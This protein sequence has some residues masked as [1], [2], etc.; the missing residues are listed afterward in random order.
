MERTFCS[1][2]PE[3]AAPRSQAEP[4]ALSSPLAHG[5]LQVTRPASFLLHGTAAEGARGLPPRPRSGRPGHRV[6]PGFPAEGQVGS[7]RCHLVVARRAAPRRPRGLGKPSLPPPGGEPSPNPAL[8][9][10]LIPHPPAFHS[11]QQPLTSPGSV[12]S[13]RGSSVPGSPSSI[14][15]STSQPPAPSGWGRDGVGTCRTAS[16]RASLTVVL[17]GLMSRENPEIQ[18]RFPTPLF[19]WSGPASLYPKC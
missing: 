19:S 10:T 13:S 11:P 2:G 6:G 9:R 18:R 15:V 14:V 1:R 8:A 3:R 16:P 7:R 17:P 5:A 4:D 12:S